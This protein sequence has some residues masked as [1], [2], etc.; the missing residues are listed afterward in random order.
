MGGFTKIECIDQRNTKSGKAIRK[1]MNEQRKEQKIP[2][3]RPK[4]R[5]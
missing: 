1:V 2:N 5:S 3:R 4:W